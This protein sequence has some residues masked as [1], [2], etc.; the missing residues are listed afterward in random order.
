MLKWFKRTAASASV[1]QGAAQRAAG[2]RQRGNALLDEGKPREALQHYREAVAL[3]PSPEAFVSLGYTLSELGLASEAREALEQAVRMDVTQFDA[4]Y[5]L[6]TL[7]LAGADYPLAISHLSRALELQPGTDMVL[8]DLCSACFLEGDLA[9]AREV[10]EAGVAAHPQLPDFHF[11]LGNI[12]TRQGQAAKAVEC[13]DTALRIKPGFAEAQHNRALALQ[14]AGRLDEAAQGLHAALALRPGYA[15]A[16]YGLASVLTDQHRPREAEPYC[17]EALALDSNDAEAHNALG[18]VLLALGRPDDAVTSYAR[19]LAL[20]DGLARVHGNLG[21]ARMAQDRM[22]PALESLR[23]AVELDPGYARGHNNLGIALQR[24]GRLEEAIAAYGRALELDPAL[25]QAHSNFAAAL[26]AQ[27]HHERAITSWRRALELQPDFFD[28]WSNL[29]YVMS[30][31][32][33]V[34]PREYLEE[35]MR[36][37]RAAA[38]RTT[39]FTAWPS[40]PATALAAGEPLRVGFV[41]GDFREHPVGFFLEGILGEIDPSRLTLI[42]YPTRPGEDRLTARIKPHFAA[43]TSLAGLSDE[44][45]AQQIHSDG[46]HMLVDLAGHSEHNRLPVF[47]WR[48]APVQLAWLGYFAS[49]GMPGIDYLVADHPGVPQECRQDFTEAIRYMPDTRLCFTAPEGADALRVG[50]LPALSNGFLTFGCFQN[51]TKL[52]DGVLAL[53]SKVFRALPGARLRHQSR[54]MADP[55]L[56]E[57]LFQR[58]ERHGIARGR[59]EL[60]G[61]T[62]RQAYLAAHQ[63]VDIMLDTFPYTGATTT[64]ESLWMGV[65][66]MSLA[67]R[68]LLARQGASLLTCAGLADWVAGDE[69]GFVSHLVKQCADLEALA[70]LRA[71]LRQQVL[72]S[73]LFDGSL[74]ARNLESLMLDLW[75]EWLAQEADRTPAGG[76]A[77]AA[78]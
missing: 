34:S 36:L 12:L 17:R 47:A 67:G 41:S 7:A 21:V 39:P 46:V 75:R 9:R 38:A 69:D 64:C 76:S 35:A 18:N 24:E 28:A 49:T 52:N 53:W 56:R 5:L 2:A 72:A 44:E 51:M 13:F 11:Y 8:R 68:T 50:P 43:W 19:A 3:V 40:T 16:L 14:A 60:A 59:V 29:V 26:Q 74:F 32:P 4:V 63:Q 78:R 20:N 54:Q 22:G 31:L 55:A 1:P 65:P 27:G 45:A 23:R 25:A 37:G 62:S 77:T 57:Q 58:L 42:A 10:A 70:A 30:F 15:Q 33:G 66:T 71:G 6:G 73:P 48:P 61:P